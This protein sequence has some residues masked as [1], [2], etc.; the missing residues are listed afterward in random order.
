[1]VT[2]T[3]DILYLSLSVGFLVLVVF[4]CITLTYATFVLRDVSQI[5]AEV[6]DLVQRVN[7][8]IISPL[9]AFTFIMENIKPY[10][11]MFR[12][13]ISGDHG[14]SRRTSKNSKRGRDEEED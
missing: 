5:T 9:K 1:M 3:L 6:K 8:V 4:L 11:E 12:E 10:V 13:R 14:G 7:Q 2:S